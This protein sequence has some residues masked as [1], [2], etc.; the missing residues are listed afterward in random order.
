MFESS[1]MPSQEQPAPGADA[2]VDAAAVA[3]WTAALGEAARAAESDAARIDLITELETLSR[4]IRATQADLAVDFDASVRAERADRGI[5]PRMQGRGIDTQIAFARK[6][7]PHRAR[8]HLSMAKVV[9]KEMPKTLAAFRSG[10]VTEQGV[11]NLTKETTCVELDVRRQIDAEIAGNAAELVKLSE[12]QIGNQARK[13]AGELDPESV[14]RARAKAEK[15]RNVTIRPAPDTMSFLT[16]H[17]PVKQGVAVYAALRQ[18]ADSLINSGD[19]RSRGQIMADT[20]VERV[21]G[22]G[23]AAATPVSINLVVSDR[24][25]LGHGSDAAHLDGAGAIPADLARR[26]VLD[27]LEAD[28]AAWLRKVYAG[29]HGGLVAM[30]SQA[31]IVPEGL[32]RF[33]DVRDG[34]ICRNLWCDAPLR[35]HDHVTSAAAGGETREPNLQGVCEACNYAKE[36]PGW[37]ATGTHPPGQRHQVVTITPTGHSYTST[38]PPLPGQRPRPHVITMEIHRG[39]Q[40]DYVPAA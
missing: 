7:S 4:V 33:I 29:P 23:S 39:F 18:T 24:T 19:E 32:A 5:G 2:L 1:M 22:Q 26:I 36:A 25:L 6:E 11:L 14:V 34:A 35:H 37:S 40:I 31:R 30:D 8:R 27:A 10:A 16:G 13:R 3:A 21:T 12:K 17:L 38:A 20:L 9:R 15:D 28:A